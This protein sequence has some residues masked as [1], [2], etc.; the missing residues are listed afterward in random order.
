MYNFVYV[1]HLRLYLYLYRPVFR[2][3]SFLQDWMITILAP[4]GRECTHVAAWI[5]HT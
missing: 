4:T 2:K 3:L 1:L 5:E